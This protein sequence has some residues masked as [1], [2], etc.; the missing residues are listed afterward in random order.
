[1]PHPSQTL[2]AA[3][4]WG[5]SGQICKRRT[6]KDLCPVVKALVES[7]SEGPWEESPPLC[8][9]PPFY[10]PLKSSFLSILLRQCCRNVMRIWTCNLISPASDLASVSPGLSHVVSCA[11]RFDWNN[12]MM[13][14]ILTIVLVK[15]GSV[16]NI[17]SNINWLLS[18]LHLRASV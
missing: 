2:S 11:R 14:W 16:R 5:K 13:S 1:M 10:V 12:S 18:E 6:F 3:L 15:G 7:P 8:S 9:P 17:K 4:Y